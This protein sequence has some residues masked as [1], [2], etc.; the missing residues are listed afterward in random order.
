MPIQVNKIFIAP[1][2]EKLTTNYD[3]LPDSSTVQIDNANL[4]L[5]NASPADIPLLKQNLMSLPEFTLEKVVKLQENEIFGKDIL[6]HIHCSKNNNYFIDAMGILHEEVI[7]FNNTFSTVVIPQI[8][9]TY[10]PHTSHNSVGHT[11][12]TELYNFI[13]R[14]YYFQG[15]RQKYTNTLDHATDVKLWTCKNH[16]LSTYIGTLHKHHRIIYQLTY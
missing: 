5:E 9:I 4:S 11:G 10:L 6:E 13:K 14:L 8:L 2:I 12:A 15:M 3:A 16:T 7:N 1:N